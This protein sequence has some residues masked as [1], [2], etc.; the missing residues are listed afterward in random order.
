MKLDIKGIVIP[1]KEVALNILDSALQVTIYPITGFGLTKIQKLSEQLQK[2]PENFEIQ[3]EL[4][5]F[6]IKCGCKVLDDVVDF[7]VQNDMFA[8]MKLV[9]QIMQ[10]S[11]DYN[12]KKFDQGQKAKKKQKKS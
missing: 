11:G 9:E 6:A 1:T 7:I 4:V 10:F 2:E 5:R 12:A 3:Q 8:S